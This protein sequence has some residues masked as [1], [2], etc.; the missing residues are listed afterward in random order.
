MA[1]SVI[2]GGNDSFVRK[3]VA[4][5]YTAINSTQES[6]IIKTLRIIIGMYKCVVRA[7]LKGDR[8][9]YKVLTGIQMQ[10]CVCVYVF[11]CTCG[12]VCICML[13]NPRTAC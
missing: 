3:A 10:C 1:T 6:D 9:Y 4:E 8:R 5:K 12:S 2:T 13:Y 11:A 7:G